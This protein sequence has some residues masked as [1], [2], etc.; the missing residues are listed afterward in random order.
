MREIKFRAWVKDC[1]RKNKINKMFYGVENTIFNSGDRVISGDSFGELISNEDVVLMQFTGLTDKNGKEIYEGDIIK[2][3]W[4]EKEVDNFEVIWENTGWWG[5][6]KNGDYS[7]GDYNILE[8]IGNIYENPELSDVDYTTDDKE[9]LNEIRAFIENAR[10][11]GDDNKKIGK[12]LQKSG[13]S[14]EELKIVFDE[15][16]DVNYTD[17]DYEGD[18]NGK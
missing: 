11:S 2:A 6:G 10:K 16:I 1:Y 7:F 8:V 14:L 15:L 13:C 17:S 9:R 3:V 12:N 18:E 4:A 5:R